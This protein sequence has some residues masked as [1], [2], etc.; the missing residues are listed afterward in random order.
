MY[1]WLYENIKWFPPPVS[2]SLVLTHMH[3]LTHTCMDT[4]CEVRCCHIE[5]NISMCG[6]MALVERVCQT[7]SIYPMGLIHGA[8][9]STHAHWKRRMLNTHTYAYHAYFTLVVLLPLDGKTSRSRHS[10]WYSSFIIECIHT[11]QPCVSAC[12]LC[13]RACVRLFISIK[14]FPWSTPPWIHHS[15]PRAPALCL[16]HFLLSV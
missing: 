13:W 12:S 11:P 7:W 1:H 16:I 14:H 15:F 6:L 10:R 5:Y 9:F 4:Q 2:C 8:S 3:R